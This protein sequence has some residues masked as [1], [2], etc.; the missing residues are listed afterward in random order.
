MKTTGNN[1]SK[2]KGESLFKKGTFGWIIAIHFDG[3]KPYYVNRLNKDG[4]KTFRYNTAHDMKRKH[5]K[6]SFFCDEMFDSALYVVESM[7]VNG[8]TAVL[9]RCTKDYLNFESKEGK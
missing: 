7:I 6:P 8:Y 1:T 5:L 3:C 9:V 2:I 4:H